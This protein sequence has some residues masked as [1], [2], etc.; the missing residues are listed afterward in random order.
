MMRKVL[1]FSLFALLIALMGSCKKETVVPEPAPSTKKAIVL[2]ATMADYNRATDTSFEEG[3]AVGLYIFTTETFVDNGRYTYKEGALNSNGTR[4]WYEDETLESTLVAYYP[5]AAAWKYTPSGVR[6]DVQADQSTRA[7]YTTSD[8]MTATTTATPTDEAVTLPFRHMLAKV[9]VYIDNQ[10]S[11][12]ITEVKLSNIA[13]GVTLD[14]RSLTLVP[15][16]EKIEIK[17]APVTIEGKE[18][19]QLIL[20]P[21]QGAE[22]RLDVTTA[23][24]KRYAC[25]LMEATDL[26]SGKQYTARATLTAIKEIKVDADYSIE[27]WKQGATIDFVRDES[28]EEIPIPTPGAVADGYSY[29]FDMEALPEIHMT[30]S[31]EQWNELL[32]SYDRDAN[33]DEYIHCDATFTKEGQTH[34]FTDVGLRLRGN[35]SR[36]RPEGNG[37][38]LHNPLDPDYHHVHFMLNLR[39]YQKDDE[40]ELGGVRKIHLKW[41][42]DDPCYAREIFCYDLFRRYG[43]WTALNTSYCRL[44]LKVG[45]SKE[46]Y[47]GVYIMLEAADERYLKK[48]ID[49]FGNDKGFLWKCGWSDSG[50][51]AGLDNTNDDR[52]WHDDNAGTTN[53]AYCLKT[54]IENFEAAKEQIKDF[55]LKLNGKT[56]DSFKTWIEQ[57]TD[58]ELLLKTYAV[59][60]AVGMWDDYWCNQNNYYLYFNSTDKENYQFFFIPY[61]Y[62]NTL[63]TSSIIDSGRQDPLN[64]DNGD[65]GRQ[66]IE[67]LLKY[68][69]YKQIYLNALQEICTSDHL[70]KPSAATARIQGWHRMIGN[71]VSNDTGEDME[72]KDRPAGWGNHGEYRLLELGSNNFF[73]V[74]AQHIAKK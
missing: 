54:E 19:W 74:K 63:G 65:S 38:E 27:D 12:P 42:K 4:Y 46:A 60:V 55:I 3:D 16:N 8:L 58:V 61:D 14:Q 15:A 64:W 10:M 56:G 47:Y 2:Q 25:E 28:G 44:W 36:R 1:S 57:V 45:I 6:F 21:Q 23:S 17:A 7:G 24:G 70:M 48:R 5:Y 50:F 52:F 33:T 69:E 51:G 18:A 35:T 22:P 9:I 39:K 31:E 49:K 13:G 71:Y 67:K 72:I 41:H 30:I 40:H 53:R 59:N 29:I 73:E 11:E 34:S 26:N 32:T 43:I 66:L 68:E 37:G 62:D 20:A